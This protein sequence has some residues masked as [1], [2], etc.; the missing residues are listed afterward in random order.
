L[1]PGTFVTLVKKPSLANGALV[2][3][4]SGR[5]IPGYPGLWQLYN[6]TLEVHLAK[7]LDGKYQVYYHPVEN[8]VFCDWERLVEGVGL[9]TPTQALRSLENPIDTGATSPSNRVDFSSELK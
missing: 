6:E 3:T 1:Q 2:E 4:P 5:R 8:T 9:S 7:P